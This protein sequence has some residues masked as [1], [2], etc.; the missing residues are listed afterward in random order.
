MRAILPLLLFGASLITFQGTARAET[1]CTLV[2]DQKTFAIIHEDG[3]CQTRHGAQSTFKIPLAVMGFD[4]GILKDRNNPVWP[5]DPKIETNRE[6][7][8]HE[9]DPARWEKDSV[10]WFSQRLTRTLGIKKFKNYVEQ[11][12]YGNKDISG[13]AGKNNGLTHSWLSSSLKI[14]P[15]EQVAFL[16]KLLS[17]DL[18][19]SADAYAK[20]IQIIPEFSIDGWIVKGKTGTGFELKEDGSWNRERQQGWFVGWAKKDSRTVLFANF[21]ADDQKETL[22]AGPRTR[23]A[24]LKELPAIMAYDRHNE[25]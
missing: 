12:N 5:Y 4:S 14:S 18:G 24:F 11:F 20:T 17:G 7:E 6:E 19:V 3:D 1:G 25:H 10:V 15:V 23:D 22:Y 8:R 16:K 9:T 2:V 13:D 21:I